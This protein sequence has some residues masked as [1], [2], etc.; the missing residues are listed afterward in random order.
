MSNRKRTIEEAARDALGL[1]ASGAGEAEIAQ[2]AELAAKELGAEPALVLERVKALQ[3]EA[4][5]RERLIAEASTSIWETVGALNAALTPPA[6]VD[7]S[8]DPLAAALGLKDGAGAEP[9]TSAEPAALDFA[10]LEGRPVGG[11]PSTI[12]LEEALAGFGLKPEHVL[13]WGPIPDG[14][15]IVTAG[16]RKLGWPAD[17]DRVLTQNEKDGQP[18]GP[19]HPK[20]YLSRTKD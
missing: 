1:I 6:I 2:A 3:A 17:K 10:A 14:L 9:E 7:P 16:G 15:R 12:A 13:A 5:T 20:G 19:K 4:T 18:S 11:Q 8:A